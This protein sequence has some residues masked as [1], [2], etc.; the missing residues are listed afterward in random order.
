MPLLGVVRERGLP[1]SYLTAGQR[2]PEDLWRAT[3]GAARRGAAART[4]DGGAHVSL[5]ATA[6]AAAAGDHASP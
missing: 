3:P 4:G 5:T 1:V 6:G 2:V